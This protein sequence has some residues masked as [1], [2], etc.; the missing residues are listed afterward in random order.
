MLLFVS[1]VVVVNLILLVKTIKATVR[2]VQLANDT[3]KTCDEINQRLDHI[4]KLRS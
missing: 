2:T 3:A 4:K 1:S